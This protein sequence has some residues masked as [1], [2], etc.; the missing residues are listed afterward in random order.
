MLINFIGSPS[1]GKTTLA[2]AT[3]AT[4]KA[5]GIPVEYVSEQA[6]VYIAE[7]RVMEGLHPQDPVSLDDLDQLNIMLR[8]GQSEDVMMRACGPDVIVISDSSPLNSLLY[9]TPEILARDVS[10]KQ[11]LLY[12]SQIEQEL[13][14]KT[15]YF[16]CEPITSGEALDPN[17][18]HN[19]EQILEIQER[20][21]E[22]LPRYASFAHLISVS[23]GIRERQNQVWERIF[24]C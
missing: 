8:Q 24:P 22:V 9:M 16:L 21:E 3:F 19:K 20:I 2:A 15:L 7:K 12:L 10:L 18:V 11:D 6:R 17:R 23:G 13:G 4:L 5:E 1:S 14:H